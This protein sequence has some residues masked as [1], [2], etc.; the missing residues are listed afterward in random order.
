MLHN[1]V[2]FLPAILFKGTLTFTNMEGKVSHHT[3]QQIELQF[4]KLKPRSSYCCSVQYRVAIMVRM[5]LEL[6]IN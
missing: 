4:L 5:V 1:F 3:K 6:G 2:C